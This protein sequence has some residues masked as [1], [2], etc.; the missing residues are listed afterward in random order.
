VNE[1]LL[2]TPTGYGDW[3]FVLVACRFC[4]AVGA[5][6]VEE[7]LGEYREQFISLGMSQSRMNADLV[8]WDRTALL[9][10]TVLL[11]RVRPRPAPRWRC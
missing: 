5:K 3:Q 7:L 8:C 9:L 11:G 2:F 10:L 6:K 4:G 1:G